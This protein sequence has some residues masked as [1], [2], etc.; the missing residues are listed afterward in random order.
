ML[1]S[2]LSCPHSH[3]DGTCNPDNPQHWFK[4]FLDSDADIYCQAY[5]IDD[6]PTLPPEFVAQLKK[7]YAGTV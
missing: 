2:R 7:E 5:T 1:K 4:R 6:N 3:F